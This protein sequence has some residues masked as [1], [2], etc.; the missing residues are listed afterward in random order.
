MDK[1]TN[2]FVNESS[3]YARN[4]Q[5]ETILIVLSIAFFLT[6]SAP[7]T[8]G[9]VILLIFLLYYIANSY[10]TIK[11]STIDD[12]NKITMIKLQTL[13]D[14]TN[15]YILKLSKTRYKNNPKLIKTLLDKY[16]LNCLY[17]DANLISFLYY[18]IDINKYNPQEFFT[19]L[20]GTNNIL[21]LRKQIEEYYESNKQLPE[22][23]S[24]MFES[25]IQLKTKVINNMHNFIYTIPKSTLMYQ[26]VNDIT[27]R[28]IV[29]ITRNTDA[30]NYYYKKAL[31]QKPTTMTKFVSYNT[32]K[33]FD[34]HL[35]H[36]SNQHK[37]IDFY[38]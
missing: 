21:C 26:Y 25:S 23:I 37:L 9:F 7:K 14:T 31:N 33:P 6:I 15:N 36:D 38:I 2:L 35:N 32:T 28:F 10:V 8:Y 24:E 12:F 34:P 17:L 22:N 30:I 11:T 20:N 16:Q 13:Q 5:F 4:L 19:L 18:I 27:Q 3:T 29:L 1:L